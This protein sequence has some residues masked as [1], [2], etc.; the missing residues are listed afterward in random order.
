MNKILDLI[1]SGKTQGAKLMT[2]G[3]RHGDQGFFVQPTVFADVKDDM[4]ICKEGVF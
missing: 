4:R 1:N 2:G 3:K